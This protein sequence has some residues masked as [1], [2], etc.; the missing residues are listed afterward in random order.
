VVVSGAFSNAW[1][2]RMDSQFPTRTPFDLAPFT[3]VMLAASSG[4]SSPLS[5]AS[6][7]SLRT[8]VIRTLIETEPG[9]RASKAPRQ[10]FTVALVNPGRGSWPNHS[11]NSSSPRLYTR[12]VIGEETESSTSAFSRR[13][14]AA[15]LPTPKCS[16]FRLSA[17]RQA[18]YWAI[19][20]IS[21]VGQGHQ[22]ESA[23]AARI[24]KACVKPRRYFQRRFAAWNARGICP[25]MGIPLHALLRSVL[26]GYSWV[27]V[28]P[29]G[30]TKRN[31]GQERAGGHR[32][33]RRGFTRGS[34][35]VYKL[36]EEGKAAPKKQIPSAPAA[37]KSP[38]E[39][40]RSSQ[41]PV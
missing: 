3:R 38:T 13:Q 16:F 17:S 40:R 7:A 20:D 33:R 36:P 34:Y 10:A 4:A 37:E 35:A 8:A 12:R 22:A 30:K 1:A 23:I 14:S 24:S 27:E 11:I 21:S 41:A 31:C 5:A 6:T 18:R 2:C 9:P 26:G 25:R 32:L 39:V 15:R 29:L 19:S 28:R